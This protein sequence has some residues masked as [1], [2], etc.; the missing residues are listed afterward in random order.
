VGEFA[1]ELDALAAE[2]LEFGERAQFGG[3][4]DAARRAGVRQAGQRAWVSDSGLRA[5]AGPVGCVCEVAAAHW[6]YIGRGM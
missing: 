5:S 1:D 6:P 4:G 2:G 3:V